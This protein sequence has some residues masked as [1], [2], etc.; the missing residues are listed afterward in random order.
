MELAPSKISTVMRGK[1]A[2]ILEGAVL[3]FLI[4]G[5]N[6]PHFGV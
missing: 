3:I 6:S 1:W 5:I 2:K 4:Y